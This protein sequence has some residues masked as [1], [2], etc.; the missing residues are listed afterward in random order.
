MA[1]VTLK[2]NFVEQIREC[3]K[4]IRNKFKQS[5]EALQRRELYL[6]SRVDII[7]EEYNEKSQEIQKLLIALNKTTFQC[8]ENLSS[9]K[10]TDV[11][12]IL[13]SAIDKKITELTA[14]TSTYCSIEL[15]WNNEFETGIKEIGSIKLNSESKISNTCT[16]PHQMKPVVP[17]YKSKQLPI[18]YRCKKSSE[19]KAP[20]ELN[21]PRSIAIDYNS[22]NLYI[23]DMYTNRV[24]VFNCDGDYLFMYC[25]RIDKPAGICVFHNK[26][27]VTQW[28]GNCINTYDLEGKFLKSV[29]SEGNG[30]TQFKNPRGVDV[31]Y[32]DNS[33]YVCDFGNARVQILTEGL[34]YHSMLG[35]GIFQY[36]FHVKITSNKIFVLDRNDPCIFVFN[37]EHVVTNRLISSAVDGKQT[38]APSCFDIDR[39][40][41][42]IISDYSNHCVY[43][44]NQAGEL[45]HRFG[46]E[47]Q[48][49]GEILRPWGIV[50]DNTGRIVVVCEKNNHCLQFF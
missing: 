10:L 34:E 22:G 41:N 35:I 2:K 40:Y 7:E 9:N 13:R 21:A 17:D 12:E 44:F 47:G 45:I 48:G 33:I 11:N 37:S 27:I 30:E 15:E 6:L 25:E 28:N 38:K 5:H 42:M 4:K 16:F 1:S 19:Q 31:S 46:K 32:K 29:G 8:E 14:D 49:I 39:D 20:G 26:V 3:R 24:Q 23:A 36:P 43:I 18:A 50:L